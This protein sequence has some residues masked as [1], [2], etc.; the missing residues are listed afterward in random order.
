MRHSRG[1]V[2]LYVVF[3]V[4]L[5][6]LFVAGVSAQAFASLNLADRLTGQLS[7]AAMLPGG[8]L[9]AQLALED[10]R[11]AVDGPTDAWV[12]DE[13]RFR[14]RSWGSGEVTVTAEAPGEGRPRYGLSDEEQRLSLNGADAAAL[15]RLCEQVGGLRPDQAQQVADA[16]ID[17]RDEDADARPFGAED[18]EYR[19][20]PDGYECKDAPFEQTEEL[21]L[22]RGVTPELY[23]RLLPHVTAFGGGWVNLNTAGVAVLSALGLSQEGVDG[24]LAYRDG[25]D[26]RSGTPDDRTLVSTAGLEGELAAFV[27]NEDLATL[28]LAAREERIGVRSTAF[29][30]SIQATTDGEASRASAWCV[31]DRERQVLIWRQE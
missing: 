1:S 11:P 21:L 8:V 18:F 14:G 12:N 24:L 3:V 6:S 29:R 23:R 30:A 31:L 15:A 17:W 5:L 20:S 25:E 9:A 4:M 22:V 28:A 27:P 2:L 13:G 26:S 7:S 19:G 16:V 10:D